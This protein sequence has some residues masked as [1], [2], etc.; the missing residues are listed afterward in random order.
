MSQGARFQGFWDLL[1]HFERWPEIFGT[2]MCD[3]TAGF[4]HVSSVFVVKQAWKRA[5]A[6]CPGSVKTYAQAP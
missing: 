4:Y 6:R 1:A 5:T 2:G 3:R